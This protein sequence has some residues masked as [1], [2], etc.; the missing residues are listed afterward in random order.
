MAEDGLN[1]VA[2]KQITQAYRS[3]VMSR[4]R[5]TNTKPEM[6]VRSRV[7]RAGYR[8][9]LHRKDLP[10]SP[11]LTF[12]RYRVVAFVHGCFW[13]WHGCKRSRMP[14][15]NREY[16]EKKIGRNVERDRSNLEKLHSLGWAVFII[17]ECE[18]DEGTDRLIAELTNRRE[19]KRNESKPE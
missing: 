10:G 3:W 6:Y 16:W 12:P 5:S 17:W 2:T 14:A 19:A 8:F 1:S 18:L 7:H 4:V 13:H 15:S 9:R 11:D